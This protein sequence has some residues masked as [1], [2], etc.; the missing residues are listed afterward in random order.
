MVAINFFN[1]Q[2]T[3]TT[4]KTTVL[5]H[6][7]KYELTE[8]AAT[9][10][11]KFVKDHVKDIDYE[12]SIQGHTDS[13]G[14]LDYN[15]KL[16]L[17][18]AEKVRQFLIQQ[19]V[20]KKLINIDYLGEIDPKKPNVNDDNRTLNRRVEVTLTAY[21]FENI[22]DLE[23]AL[24]PNKTNAYIINPVK[25]NIIKGKK[26]VKILIAPNSFVFEDGTL[27]E[28][29][30]EFKLTESL[31]YS[32]FISSGLLT[33]SSDQLL[34]SGG[35]I[36]VDAMTV[37]GKPVKIK[38]DKEMVIAIP[39]KDRKEDMEVFTSNI[40]SDW[41]AKNQKIIEKPYSI[42]N[43]PYPIMNSK[44]IRL[45]QFEVDKSNKPVHPAYPRKPRKPHEPKEE[46]YKRRIPWYKWNKDKIRA[47]QDL[48]YN[49]A[50]ER[51]EKKMDR[52]ALRMEKYEYEMLAYRLA[53]SKYDKALMEWHI[54][55]DAK[56]KAFQSTDEYQ[57]T[58]KEHN[59]TYEKNLKEHR[60]KVEQWRN[61][62]KLNMAKA[63]EQMDKLG[64]T[65]ERAMEN[66][67][68][69]FNELTWI[70]VDRFYHLKESEKQLITMT[71]NNL[72]NEKVLIL[73]KNIGS[74]LPM[75][76]NRTRETYVQE[77]FPKKEP[78]VLFAYKVQ[79]G[80]PMICYRE[81]DGRANYQ[82]DFMEASFY[83]IKSILSQFDKPKNS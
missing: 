74:T 64:I 65:S 4:K 2:A 48:N 62:R 20:N 83:E 73:F 31:S 26:G 34:E 58:L 50:L 15:K 60:L 57:A 32:D 7:A 40:G 42:I 27:V 68:F 19:G 12:I 39:D 44:N 16:S 76:L 8:E 25:E 21:R 5:F 30:I 66:Y 53:E 54:E 11:T 80:K 6:T 17:N 29:D 36:K 81:M 14:N 63:G 55:V 3:I 51:Y 67:V 82:L 9:Q 37:S 69:T 38:T 59:E 28:E 13:R 22:K 72:G 70:N 52:Y 47:K 56:R 77:N 24:D 46:S 1:A 33:K 41:T 23:A 71:G 45:P 75:T 35:M 10:L 78:A 49:R 79:N 43:A 18:R 61:N